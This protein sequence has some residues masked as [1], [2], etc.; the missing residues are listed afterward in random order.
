M[1]ETY[2]VEPIM[3][4]S[5]AKKLEGQY[6]N[7]YDFVIDHDADVYW[8]DNGTE[9]LL[10][11]FRKGIV[12][13]SMLQNAIKVFKKE[14][15]KASSLRGTAGG[16]V[17][18]KKISSNVDHVVSEGKYKSK[19]VFKNGKQSDYYVANKVNSMIAGYY[20]KPKLSNKHEVL[21]HKLVP[22][23]TT[24]FTEN[25]FKQWQSV[26]PM[27]QYMDQLYQ[28]LQPEHHADQLDLASRTPNYQIADTAFSTVTVNYNWRTA[29]HVDS[30]DFKNGYS[31]ILVAEEGKWKGGYLCYPRF[32]IC[33]DV[34]HGDFLLKDPH[35]QHANLPIE[36]I[37]QDHTRLSFVIYY[38]ENMQ[39]CANPIQTGGG[40]KSDNYYLFNVQAKKSLTTD[41]SWIE[42]YGRQE[43]TDVKVIK[44]VLYTNV[45]EKKKIDF[46]IEPNDAW[47]DLGGNIGTFALR[48]LAEGASVISYE[49][50]TEN[51]QL[52][53]KNLEHNFPN[54]AWSIEQSVV[55]HKKTNNLDLY[56]C[57]G[58][59]N[60]YRHTLHPVRGRSTVNVK[61]SYIYDV[62]DQYR[63]SAIKM[64]IEGA[65][66]EILETLKPN[67]YKKY[68]IEKLVFEYS[69]D[70][71]PSIPRFLKIVKE[72][73]KYFTLVHYTKVK[74]TELEYKYFPAATLVYCKK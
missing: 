19:V 15:V 12:P 27:L 73:R 68:G 6:I 45:Y 3:S 5:D 39:Q 64:D 2:L 74:E 67:D 50:E 71:D 60:K 36:P 55:S 10:F 14:A 69:F 37:T 24:A 47:L 33:V 62:L 61:N 1:I 22:C 59:Y 28:E 23:R 31:V 40:D 70:V 43:T 18:P 17:D 25:N 34:R 49:P 20:D 29:C 72:L 35:Q 58:S 13:D 51:Y 48:V 65:E 57:K 7:D 21:K 26:L 54:G 4:A 41:L 42:V 9:R 30:G 52:M 44:E 8:N 11:H 32:N 63:P 46:Y 16:A 56:L 66:I 38:R 53:S